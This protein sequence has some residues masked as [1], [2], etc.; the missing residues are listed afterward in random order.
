MS[1]INPNIRRL[2]T[3]IDLNRSY[4][5]FESSII[6]I[7]REAVEKMIMNILQTEK[8][9]YPF[10]PTFGVNLERYLFR[11]SHR[12][13]RSEIQSEIQSAITEWL[14]YGVLPPGGIS[15]TQTGP[16]EIQVDLRVLLNQ[17]PEIFQFT[18]AA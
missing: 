16:T 3:V 10:E 7:D 15:V 5:P 1:E 12:S 2:A 13:T 11:L 6:A 14:S 18:L 17:Q 9:T 4:T 8:G